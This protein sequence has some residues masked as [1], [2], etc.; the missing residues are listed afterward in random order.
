[1]TTDLQ[2]TYEQ[3]YR[4]GSEKFF[5]VDSFEE[6]LAIRA[7]CEWSGKRVMEIGCGEGRLAALLAMSGAEQVDA[8]DYAQTAIDTARARHILPNLAFWCA[9]LGDFEGRYDVVVLQGVLEHLDDSWSTL[10]DLIER[11]ITPGGCVI[12]SSPNF[13][14]PR[15]YI[16][17]ALQMLFDVPMSLTDRHFIS[18]PDMRAYCEEH[19]YVLVNWKTIHHDWAFGGVLIADFRR[20]LTNA[21]R[22][23]VPQGKIDSFLLWLETNTLEEWARTGNGAVGIYRIEKP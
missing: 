2:S 11:K 19:G 22:E 12:T 4:N 5:T 1:M 14:N 13:C 18:L 17:M 23:R 20:R 10:T 3:V 9:P 16:W 6:S 7:M 15:G 21:L 8:I